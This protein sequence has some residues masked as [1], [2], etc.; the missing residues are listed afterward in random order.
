VTDYLIKIEEY[1][2]FILFLTFHKHI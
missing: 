2:K 1:L